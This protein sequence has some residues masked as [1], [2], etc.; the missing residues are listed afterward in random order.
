L[1]LAGH[2]DGIKTL[3]PYRIGH[4][5]YTIEIPQRIFFFQ[6]IFRIGDTNVRNTDLHQHRATFTEIHNR[7]AIGKG[8]SRR[9]W[10]TELRIEIHRDIGGIPAE[11]SASGSAGDG[12]R[13]DLLD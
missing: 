11:M 6:I 3:I 13:V 7:T 2:L 5:L 12:F 4:R 8:R 1:V 10:L 9:E